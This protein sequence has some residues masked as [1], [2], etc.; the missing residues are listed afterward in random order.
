MDKQV[1]RTNGMF[2]EYLMERG[3]NAFCTHCIID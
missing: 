1:D 3:Q 2:D